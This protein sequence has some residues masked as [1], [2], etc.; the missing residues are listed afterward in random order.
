M[1]KV[2]HISKYYHPFIGGVEQVASD[3]VQALANDCEQKVICFNHER[4]NKIDFIDDVEIIRINCQ[5]KVASQSI[6]IS[7]GKKLRKV[8]KSFK[9]DI[10]IFHYPNPFVGH[11]VQKY[12]KKK[13]FSFILYWHL[14]ITKQKILG[15]LFAKQNKKLLR[16][17][18]KIV[19]TSPNYIEGSPWLFPNKDKCVVIPCCVNEKRLQ[20]S[21]NDIR[22]SEEIRKRFANKTICFAFGRHV[23]YKGLTYLIKT[24]KLLSDDYAILIGG[25]GPL[26]ESL[27][28]EAKDDKK[29]V[30]L[31]K[32]T[33][34]ELK[35]YLLACDIFCFPSITKN[36]AFGIGLAEA[37]Y[38]NKPAVTFTILG[39]GVNYVNVNG[40]T[41][42]EVENSNS[43]EFAKAIVKI[44]ENK[45]V[46]EPKKRV[47]EKFTYKQFQ[48]S[49]IKLIK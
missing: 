19:A 44:H 38:F 29:V 5:A 9:P 22:N 28:N 11:F 41:G 34:E 45:L 43:E 16:Y 8:I 24:S 32:I 46:F 7:Y 42:L 17:A 49:I 39:S 13:K 4:G 12:L 3:C 30:F 18:D 21:E 37:M 14:D 6:A 36:E 15:K 20:Y 40:I 23:E 2:L 47:M 26:T 10:V 1:K 31:G 33:D 25:R 35:S 27:M 48:D